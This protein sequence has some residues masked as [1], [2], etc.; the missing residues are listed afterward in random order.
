VRLHRLDAAVRTDELNGT[1]AQRRGQQTG[2]GENG[3]GNAGIEL[4]LDA[5]WNPNARLRERHDLAPSGDAGRETGLKFVRIEVPANKDKFRI[6]DLAAAPR[7]AVVA[8]HQHMDTLKNEAVGAA[9][10]VENALRAQ[11]R[12]ALLPQQGANPLVEPVHVDRPGLA[13]RHTGDRIIVLMRVLAQEVRLNGQDAVQVEGASIQNFRWR[14]R[15]T[16]GAVDDRGRVDRTQPR[17]QGRQL[18]PGTRS[19]LLSRMM[20]AKAICSAAS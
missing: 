8:F 1:I 5:G 2:V 18:V 4:C 7:F 19:D 14:Y 10:E 11:D 13:Q 3:A 15:T 20:S 17:L 9:L 6:P 16:L 12:Q